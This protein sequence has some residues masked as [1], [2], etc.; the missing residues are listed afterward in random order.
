MLPNAFEYGGEVPQDIDKLTKLPGVGRKTANVVRG[1]IYGIPSVVVDTHVRRV[2]NML[3]FTNSQDPVKIEFELMELL[4]VENWIAYNTQIIAHGRNVLREDLNAIHAFYR[5]FAIMYKRIRNGN[6]Y[7][8][9][10]LS[11][12]VVFQL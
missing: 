1:N 8:A 6:K 11:A 2:S 3:G 7:T 4:P 10:D 5:N 12:A 9:A